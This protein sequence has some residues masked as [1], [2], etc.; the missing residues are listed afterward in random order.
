MQVRYNKRYEFPQGIPGFTMKRDLR[1][2]AKQTNI[3]LVAGALLVLFV[4]GLGLIWLIYGG[5][6]ASFGFFCLLAGLSP[7][8][9]ILLVFWGI[10]WILSHARPK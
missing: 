2:Y 9:L 8:V 5:G 1:E 10:D 6:A 3:R 7:V 4:I